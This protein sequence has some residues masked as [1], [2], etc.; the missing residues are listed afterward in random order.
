[1]H[2]V[3]NFR[4]IMNF[5]CYQ[6]LRKLSSLVVLDLVVVVIVLALVILVVEDRISGRRPWRQTMF[7]S[8]IVCQLL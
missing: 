1:M 2:V 7:V 4:T 8:A 3:L 5:S 6:T